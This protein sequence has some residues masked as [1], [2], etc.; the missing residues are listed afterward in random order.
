MAESF[1]LSVLTSGLDPVVIMDVNLVNLTQ[2]YGSVPN[3]LP[4]I[5]T[6]LKDLLGC[7]LSRIPEAYQNFVLSDLQRGP[8]GFI[9]LLFVRPKSDEEKLKPYRVYHSN[10]PHTWPDVLIGKLNFDQL[11]IAA[12]GDQWN[13][14]L[15]LRRKMRSSAT[16]DSPITI[17]LFQGDHRPFP[18]KFLTYD[19]PVPREIYWNT[20]NN[21]GRLNCLHETLTVPGFYAD[22]PTTTYKETNFLDW[23]KFV[24]SCEQTFQDGAYHVKRVTIEPAFLPEP[25]YL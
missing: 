25:T 18:K 17:E 15:A 24:Y 11:R 2:A 7:N 16:L 4:P 22:M 10:Q 13:S 8:I 12:V 20:L 19:E 6:V 5:G 1:Q 3:Y 23:S 14:A 9:T 21:S